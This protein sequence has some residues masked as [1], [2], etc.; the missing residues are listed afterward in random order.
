[1]WH[2]KSLGSKES[3][4]PVIIVWLLYHKYSQKVGKLTSSNQIQYSCPQ[5]THE[6]IGLQKTVNT[7]KNF[8]FYLN[9]WAD[10]LEVLHKRNKSKNR[11]I[12]K[13]FN[14]MKLAI[15]SVTTHDNES[16]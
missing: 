16:D 13:C 10:K 14:T 9:W 6:F 4:S 5:K 12:K 15:G 1:M 2:S 11:Y 3:G 8:A 7:T